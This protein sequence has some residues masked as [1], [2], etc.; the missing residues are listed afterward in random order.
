MLPKHKDLVDPE[1]TV[2]NKDMILH[3][4]EEKQG[5][6]MSDIKTESEADTL[7]GVESQSNSQEEKCFMEMDKH[8]KNKI[9]ETKTFMDMLFDKKVLALKPCKWHAR[10]SAIR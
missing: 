7:A 2:D 5:A 6:N 3:L 8:H 1:Q 4:E 9:D 10:I